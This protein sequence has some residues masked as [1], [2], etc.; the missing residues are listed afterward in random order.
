ML[1]DLQQYGDRTS[2]FMTMYPGF[3]SYGDEQ[4][5]IRYMQT[6]RA[7]VAATEPL[8]SADKRA[9][10]FAR[11]GE[12]AVLR[13]KRP[14]ITP[15]TEKLSAELVERGY[16][17]I[18]LGAEPVFDLDEY[19]SG[20][21]DPLDRFPHARALYRRGARVREVKPEEQSDALNS[22]LSNLI[23]T[24]LGNRTT[25]PLNF[26]N[27][28]DPWKYRE[29]KKLFVLEYAGSVI[30]FVSAVPVYLR[31]GFFFADYIRA[32][33]TKVGTVE[34]L[35]IETMRALFEQG[36]S[37]V[38]LGLCP[39]AHL[40][41][42]AA[43]SAKERRT[44]KT[45]NWAFTRLKFPINF[46]SVYEFKAKF[47]PTRWEPLYLVSKKGL[48]LRTIYDVARVHFPEGVFNAWLV[49]LKRQ[50]KPHLNQ[51]ACVSVRALPKTFGEAAARSKVTLS[52]CALFTVL[53]FLRY[54]W[55]AIQRVYEANGF[56]AGSFAL[57]GWLAGPLFHN[58]HYH[59]GGD[60]LTFLVFG[61]AAEILLGSVFG[62]IVMAAGL[63]A[64]NPLAWALVESFSRYMPAGEYARFLAENDYGSSNAVYAFV[65]AVSVLLKRPSLFITPFAL[66]GMFLCFAR[67]SWL[68]LHHIVALACGYLLC[69]LWT[70]KRSDT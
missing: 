12:E 33:R 67:Q 14:I 49:S 3:E 28:V 37:E 36:Y 54:T 39:L 31:Q 42:A 24:W 61:A 62:F 27:Q 41:L 64:S 6:S 44:L 15:V 47:Q 7:W 51:A 57:S 34:L 53:H 18:Q 50:L 48:S 46:A 29:H 38:R 19:F 60:L 63:W 69:L 20:E 21:K 70:R 2:S 16:E 4:G 5:Q 59:F 25:V 22:E 45:M 8:A 23:E 26:L 55:P 68:S 11:F 32:P 35:F 30:A 43:S 56:S 65:G 58:T 52:F 1:A 66:N 10:L 13:G 9:E 17:R 40:N